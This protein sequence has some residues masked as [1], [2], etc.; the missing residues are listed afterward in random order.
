MGLI[1]QTRKTIAGKMIMSKKKKRVLNNRK[2]AANKPKVSG[3]ITITNAHDPISFALALYENANIPGAKKALLSVLHKDAFNVD[4]LYNLGIIA[5]DQNNI[6]GA[7]Q[8]YE[9]VLSIDPDYVNAYFVLGGI[10]IDQARYDEA[11]EKFHKVVSLSPDYTN[12]WYN[13]GIIAVALGKQSEAIEYY[14]KVISIDPSYTNAYY[15]I[16]WILLNQ[17]IYDEAIKY[18]QKV[19]SLNPEYVDAFFNIGSAMQTQ[20]NYKGAIEYYEKAL[21]LDPEHYLVHNNLGIIYQIQYRF[22]KAIDHYEAAIKIQPEMADAYMNMGNVFRNRGDALKAVEYYKKSISLK[23]SLV[24]YSNLCG[25]QKE[26]CNY[27][28]VRDLTQEMLEYQELDKSDLAG[29]HDTYIQTCEWEKASAVIERFK[30]TKMNPETRDVLAGSFMEFCAI[31]DL[32]LD[33]ISEQHQKWGVITEAAVQPFEH[34]RKRLSQTQ[35][36]KLRIG[37]SSPDLREH[38]VGYLI[39]DIIASHNTDEFDVYCY[40]NFFPKEMDAFS[41]EMIKASLKFKYVKDLSDMEV[42][43]E[44][45]KDEIDILID[46]AGHTAGHRLR[47]FAYK[48][49]PIQ[50][51][52]LG[53]P[54]TTGLSRMDYRFT[55]RYAESGRQNDY[56]YSEKLIRLTNCFLGFNGFGNVVPPQIKDHG[57]VGIIFGCFNNIQKLTPKAV[58]LWSK[59]LKRVVGSVLHLKAKQLNTKFVWD[60]IIKEFAR[61]GISEERVKCLGYTATREEHLRLYNTIDISLDTF[62]YNGTVTTLE[63]LWMNMPVM[64]LVGESHAQRVSYSI[65]KNLNLDQLIAFTEEEYVSKSVELAEHPE[66]I[67]EL[68]TRMRKNLLASSICNPRV[69]AREMELNFKAIWME[70]LSSGIRDQGS[71]IQKQDLIEKGQA[72]E[73]VVQDAITAASRLRM[74]MIKLEKGEYVQAVEISSALVDEK[75]VA[76]LAW[77]ILGIS[78]FRLGR[79]EKAIKAMNTSLGLNPGNEGAWKVLR[80]IYL[81]KGETDKANECLERITA[82]HNR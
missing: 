28:E 69:I 60:N 13:L 25:Y 68:K 32:T 33:E 64:T 49:A 62:P 29:I 20:H 31:T 51:T 48:P 18:F 7:V 15:N 4:A 43:K 70:Y 5:K 14:E 47:A 54:N 8:Y 27:K 80:E 66:I 55:D 34:E 52:Y 41:Q 67:R 81:S 9:K 35:T 12:A 50:I 24:G 16:A 76:Y 40:A 37:Y 71:G 3:K 73:D 36:R 17:K 11:H 53:Y 72:E 61:H 65:L 22:D 21:S 38:S 19:I 79:V 6:D 2:K 58:E 77:Y 56:R 63:A 45:Y 75:G 42:A 44:I 10:F 39:K 57:E 26:L 30:K 23:P 46:L 82:P 78:Y 74:A 59:I 1:C